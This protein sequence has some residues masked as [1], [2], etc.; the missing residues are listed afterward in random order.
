MTNEIIATG[1]FNTGRLYSREGQRIYWAQRNDGW[2]YFN[3]IDRM[4]DGWLPRDMHGA[5]A[6]TISAAELAKPV[7]PRWLMNRYD[8]H[9]YGYSPAERDGPN[10]SVPADFDFGAALRI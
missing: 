3:D 8:N 6:D 9:K 1:G 2:L 4:I 10:P 5:A 7:S